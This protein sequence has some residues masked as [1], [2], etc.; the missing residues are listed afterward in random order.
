MSDITRCYRHSAWIAACSDCTAWHLADV[1][2]RRNEASAGP[3]SVVPVRRRRRPARPAVAG[4]P[5][6]LSAAA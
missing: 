2:A 5:E 6:R 1:I 3:A 4:R